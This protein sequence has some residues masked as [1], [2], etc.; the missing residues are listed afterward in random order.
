MNFTVRILILLL[1]STVYAFTSAQT[2]SLGLISFA[3]ATYQ[4]SEAI[5]SVSMGEV[6]VQTYQ[7]NGIIITEGFQQPRLGDFYQIIIVPKGWSGISS[8]IVP[9]DLT[10]DTIFS[11]Y[12]YD[13]LIINNF[14]SIYVL[15]VNN[16]ELEEWKPNEAKRIKVNEGFSVKYYG[17]RL[18]NTNVELNEGWNILP[19]LSTCSVSCDSIQSWLGSSF[20]MIIEIGND[21]V[22]WPDKNISTLQRLEPGKAYYLKNSSAAMLQFPACN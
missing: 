10:L 21:K 5:M 12:E 20:E 13:T 16:N 11:A 8:F 9:K 15:G 18:Q 6:G 3:G 1:F 14:D 7:Q 22:F 19:V 17:R 2:I 4:N